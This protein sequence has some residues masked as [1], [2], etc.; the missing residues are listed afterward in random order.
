VHPKGFHNTIFHNTP[1]GHQAKVKNSSWERVLGGEHVAC[2]GGVSEGKGVRV[3][4]RQEATPAFG[5]A[6]TLGCPFKLKIL[7][8]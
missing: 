6:K 1:P 8:N 4:K 3:L 2:D 7:N 5:L